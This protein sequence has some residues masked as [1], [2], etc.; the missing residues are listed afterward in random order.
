MSLS[1]GLIQN[2]SLNLTP[3][4]KQSLKLLEIDISELTK[5]LEEKEKE[6]PILNV[7]TPS[8][9]TNKY[10]NNNKFGDNN[11]QSFLENTAKDQPSLDALIEQQINLTFHGRSNL[12]NK[13][14]AFILYEGLNHNGYLETSIE[15]VA[16][17]Y[18]KRYGEKIRTTEIETVLKK[19]QNFEPM[20]IFARNLQECMLINARSRP[21]FDENVEIIIANIEQIAKGKIKDI[22]KKT[23]LSEAEILKLV[24]KIKQFNLLPARSFNSQ[25]A[26]TVIPDV[27]IE[28]DELSGKLIARLNEDILPK[29]VV[30][31]NMYNN[32]KSMKLDKD[33]NEFI[34][35]NYNE[36]VFYKRALEQRYST[37]L[38]VTNCILAKQ[39]GFFEFGKRALKPMTLSDIANEI[40][41][42]EST[43]SRAV[44]HKYM[45]S[46]QGTFELKY[47][48]TKAIDGSGAVNSFS[49]ESIKHMIKLMIENEDPRKPLSD[50]KIVA[51]L[52]MQKINI[53]RRTVTKYREMLKIPSSFQ[54]KKKI[55][56]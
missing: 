16:S 56:I 7:I 3:Q 54:R 49:N 45:L 24:G 9:A 8:I 33:A 40:G 28:K 25:Q 1:Q 31:S 38:K 35:N 10:S 18:Q 34:K 26:I 51:N 12:K 48:F 19:C 14:I 17:I 44:N 37:L 41:M 32:Y 22:T 46:P 47:F 39:K 53:A 15:E 2:N 50:D 55:V 4:L 23:K 13:N 20:G 36:A 6:N 27:L 11:K 5:I 43:I 42:H 30:N 52:R 29:V 21:W